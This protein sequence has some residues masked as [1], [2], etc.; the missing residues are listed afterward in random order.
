MAEPRKSPEH[1]ASSTKNSPAA[2][3]A[4]IACKACNSR[5]VKCDAVD[6]QP[7]WHCRLRQTPCELIESKRGKYPRKRRSRNQHALCAADQTAGDAV[8][9]DPACSTT[10]SALQRGRQKAKHPLAQCAGPSQPKFAKPAQPSRI[11]QNVHT[12]H[13]LPP[14]HLTYTIEILDEPSGGSTEPLKVH[15]AIPASIAAQTSSAPGHCAAEPV[16]LS[17]AVATPSCH[18]ARPLIRAFFELVHPAFPV[19]DRRDFARLYAQGQVSPLVLQAVFMVGFTVCSESLVHEAGYSNRERARKTHYLR[20]KALYDA[21]HEKN[22][23][24]VVAAVL[25]LGFWW[26]GP[27]DQKD[28][29]YWVGCATIL[30]QSFGMHRSSSQSGMSQSVRSLRKRIWWSI[31]VRDRHTAAAFG[32][33]CRIRDDDCD[34]EPL[35]EDD[36]M[37][38]SDYDQSVVPSQESFHISYAI[39]MSKLAI[40]LG[41][42]LIAE[43]SP[44]HTAKGNSDPEA[45][46]HR[47]KQWEGQIPSDLRR[48]QLDASIGAPFW[49]NMLY[50]SYYN[51]H[52]LL[53]RAK[54]L[55]GLSPAEADM[56]IRAR[57]AADSITRIAEDLLAARTIKY[58]QVLLVPAL[59]GA[60]S[61]HTMTLCREDCIRQKLAENKSR[62]CLLALCELSESWPVKIWFAKAFAN[63][64]SRLTGIKVG[65]IVSVPSG[66]VDDAG[67]MG[68][69][70]EPVSLP[71]RRSPAGATSWDLIAS[72]FLPSSEPSYTSSPADQ[73]LDG[74]L[75]FG[76]IDSTFTPDMALCNSFEPT[77]PAFDGAST[78]EGNSQG[79]WTG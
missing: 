2:H 71:R 67:S 51:C 41:D 5:R 13:L 61:V 65:S 17:D 49:A 69:S 19:L 44:G 55:G 15:Y 78:E 57:I 68:F 36:F 53:F 75:P 25:L 74:L 38:D 70:E 7:C 30:A 56:D 8:V 3:R 58:A 59:F 52:V 18:I 63:L 24:S 73:L 34:I 72:D 22:P 21:D 12:P 46:A 48:T 4:R 76:R 42:I 10:D 64:M 28:Y 26:S 23:L 33:P 1:D 54:P 6:Q 40:L 35:T 29:C 43:F 47:L 66:I 27:E 39:E 50:T 32:R 31:Y 79:I 9:T 45:L 14:L 11:S 16:A 37:F 60:L 62:Q 20:A 77:L